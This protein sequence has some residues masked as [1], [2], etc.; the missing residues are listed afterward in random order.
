M[1]E[2]SLPTVSFYS[3]VSPS[4]LFSF[5]LFHL[6]VLL[7]WSPSFFFFFSFHPVILFVKLDKYTKN[8]SFIER[9]SKSSN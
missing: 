9:Y 5:L 8:S 7:H 4:I 1:T 6:Y 3:S 2:K